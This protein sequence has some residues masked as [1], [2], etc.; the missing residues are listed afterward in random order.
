[1]L[2][3]I[4]SA[5]NVEPPKPHQVNTSSQHNHKTQAVAGHRTKIS[6]LN[7][8]SSQAVSLPT[9][10]KGEILIIPS[11]SAPSFNG[12]FTIDVKNVGIII[13]SA[14]L[15]FQYSA[16]SGVGFVGSFNP[17]W[18]H[19]N[20]IEILQG[21]NVMDTIYGNQQFLLNQMLA[22]DEDRLSINNA[23]GN[24]SLLEQRK[25]LAS[26]TST[27]TYYIPLKTY[28]SQSKLHLLNATDVLQFRVYVEPYNNLLT[29]TTGS[30]ISCTF[31]SANLILDVTKVDQDEANHRITDMMKFN[32]HWIYHSTSFYSATVPSGISSYTAILASI[33]GSCAGFIFTLRADTTKA[34]AFNYTQLSSFHLL[35]NA[36]SSITGGQPLPAAYCANIYNSQIC[37]SSYNTETSFGYANNQNANFYVYSFSTDFVD[38]LLHGRSLG[39][40]RFT[41]QESII[42]NFA[43]ATTVPLYL[44]VYA[45]IE[46]VI[47]Q[48]PMSIK[49]ISM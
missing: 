39:S 35:D 8:P 16:V 33:V 18:Y 26:G 12:F 5:Q 43:S 2:Y 22:Y 17:A 48:T 25:L 27:N 28:L 46:N 32:H 4:M 41:G 3:Y 44:D 7:L 11:S 21:G 14:V 36:S 47:D 13:H 37:Q 49:K 29:I 34:N 45:M 20:R 23:A 24:Y 30:N 42:L 6:G 38:S 31:Q 19:F 40:R 1:M 15:Q 10:Q 9:N